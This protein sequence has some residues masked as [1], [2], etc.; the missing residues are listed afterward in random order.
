MYNI[1]DLPNPLHALHVSFD[2]CPYF[3]RSL[4]QELRRNCSRQRQLEGS[5]EIDDR[6]LAACCLP[7]R[8]L[9]SRGRCG[10][11]HA[12]GIA[13]IAIHDALP[14]VKFDSSAFHANYRS[15]R[16]HHI[17]SSHVCMQAVCPCPRGFTQLALPPVGEKHLSP[18]SHA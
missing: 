17:L 4:A 14:V 15:E 1:V 16:G 2:N 18:F 5:P 7:S 9:T 13:S 6:T 12:V 3:Y 8:Y 11:C 10:R